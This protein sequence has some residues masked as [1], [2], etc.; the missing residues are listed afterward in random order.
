MTSTYTHIHVKNL[1]MS[2][3]WMS[4]RALSGSFSVSVHVP[5]C[6]H[7]ANKRDGKNTSLERIKH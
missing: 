3:F 2:G 5:T 1:P 6:A 7:E 4:G